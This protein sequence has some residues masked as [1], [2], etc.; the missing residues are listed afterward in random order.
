MMKEATAG[1]LN[2]IPMS[3]NTIEHCISRMTSDVKEKLLGCV[4]ES[5]FFFIQPDDATKFANCA[6]LM[7]NV[8]YEYGISP[9]Y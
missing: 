9:Y 8:H 3:D 1:E 2:V 6:Q 7:A 4:C 5:P